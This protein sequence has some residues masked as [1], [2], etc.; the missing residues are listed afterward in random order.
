[1]HLYSNAAG[2]KAYFVVHPGADPNL[3][4]L[5]FSGIDSL[6]VA[7]NVLN[8]YLS[9][10][11]LALPV[12]ATY[13][14]DGGGNPDI[15]TTPTVYH[16]DGNN[17]VSFDVGSYTS[18][19]PLMIQIG[20][21]M[22]PSP[23]A[24]DNLCWSTYYGDLFLDNTRS[25]ATDDDGNLYFAGNT[26]S[27]L[28]P[29]ASGTTVQPL[30]N[31]DDVFIIKI[32]PDAIPI[33]GSFLGG[34]QYEEVFDIALNSD[35][36]V[37]ITGFTTSSDFPILPTGNSSL[38]GQTDA[39]ITKIKG[40]DGDYLW[41][42]FLGGSDL[43]QGFS[44]E[45]DQFDHVIVAGFTRSYDFPITP[46]ANAY[47]Q[48]VNASVPLALEAFIVE[49]NPQHVPIWG[50]YFGGAQTDKIY[51]LRSNASNHL[52]VT[53]V[54]RTTTPASSN[55]NN[56]PCEAPAPGYFPDCIAPGSCGISGSPST[57]PLPLYDADHNSTL[58]YFQP[59]MMGGTND[60]FISR[61]CLENGMP[62]SIPTLASTEK[63][64]AVYPNP[65]SRILHVHLAK[66]MG[67]VQAEIVNPVGQIVLSLRLSQV[68]N[69]IN[70]GG[71]AHGIYFVRLQVGA[72]VWSQKFIY[73]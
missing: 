28:F 53:G 2:M 39:I 45:V 65:T 18:T 22:V 23:S 12:T 64:W 24:Q 37:Y 63:K 29:F 68:E 36:D 56:L 67:P 44:I 25:L 16:D 41:G 40:S 54:T 20:A 15:L 3:I 33:W 8:L 49:F 52:I 30:F 42:R 17:V 6:K 7:S 66:N 60:A 50:T 14:L 10:D 51:K 47:N 34:T 4:Q 13:Q 59:N 57:M 1:M 73:Q 31:G 62:T 26:N 9:G 27:P 11:V 38:S 21:P 5:Q 55:P 58:D 72:T 69:E 35:K 71:L 61:F 19:E 46:K 70:L 43:E 32:D 48:P